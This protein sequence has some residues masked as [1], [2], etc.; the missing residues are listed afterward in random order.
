[1]TTQ[2]PSQTDRT[3]ELLTILADTRRRAILTALQDS[4]SAVTSV[5]QLAA[6]I[7]EEDHRGDDVTEIYLVHSA[8]PKLAA[9]GV[10]DFDQRSMAV[11]YRAT[12]ALEEMLQFVAEL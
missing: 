4:P 2:Q 5:D 1:M 10:V 8:L 12:P 7:D 3:D 6:E 11:R 9:A